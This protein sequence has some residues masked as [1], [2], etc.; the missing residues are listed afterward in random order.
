MRTTTIEELLEDFEFLDSWED[1][2][3][4]IIE[5]GDELE[6][7]DAELR[8][9]ENRVQGCVS[10]VWLIASF[11]ASSP[12]QISF[13][14]D[15][16]S[17]L[18]RGLVSILIMLCNDQPAPT[19]LALDVEDLFTRLELRNHLSR[20]RSNGLFSMVKR[21]RVLAAEGIAQADH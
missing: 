4:Y 2:Y 12:P 16:D 8:V 19:V 20:S 13:R 21:I 14:A 6:D 5:L 3:R 9:E 1:R 11:D 18:V 17:Q 10:N 15:S 7:L